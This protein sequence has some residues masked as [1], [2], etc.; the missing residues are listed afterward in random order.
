VAQ[1]TSPQDLFEAVAEEVGR[2]LPV[3]SATMGRFEP[4]ECVTTMASWSTAE[5]AFPTGRRWP[6]EGTNVAWM[7]LRTGRAARIDDFSAATDPIGVAAR[8]AG[9]KSAV[10]SP[11]VVEGHLW[12]VLTATS[13]EGPLPPGTEERLASCTELVATAI[14]NAESSAELAASRR[15]I[16]AASDDARRRIERDLHDGAQQHL[17][18]LVLDALAAEASAPVELAELKHEMS[19][20]ASGLAE[21]SMELQEISHGIH[22]AIL[23]RQCLST[24]TRRSKARF[25]TRSR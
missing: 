3:V 4:D 17:V 9:Y 21:V 22:P 7:V 6:T 19:R 15:R 20:I 14:A 8:E 24:C 10:G 2:L 12:G 16:V 11:I 25:P 18:T 13:S 5:V 1:G 23:A